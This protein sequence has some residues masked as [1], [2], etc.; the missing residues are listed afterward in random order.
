M[1]HSHTSGTQCVSDKATFAGFEYEATFG[2]VAFIVQKHLAVA[3][4]SVDSFFTGKI[5]YR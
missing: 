2:G 3:L 1:A 5:D 4:T